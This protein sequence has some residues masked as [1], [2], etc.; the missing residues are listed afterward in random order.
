MKRRNRRVPAQAS[1]P[2][3]ADGVATITKPKP[4]QPTHEQIQ[5]RAYKI[6]QARSDAPGTELSDWLQAEHELK[7]GLSEVPEG[8]VGET[9]KSTPPRD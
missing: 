7:A 2:P 5:R 3:K 8:T 9:S 6:F 4:P 1:A